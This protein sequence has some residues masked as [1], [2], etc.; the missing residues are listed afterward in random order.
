VSS[1][2][3]RNTLR[4][5]LALWYA[6]AGLA[7]FVAAVMLALIIGV[8]VPPRRIDVVLVLVVGL[9]GA[10]CALA[11]AGYVVAGRALAPLAVMAERARRLSASSLSER[12]PVSDP[13][14]EIGRLAVIFNATLDRLEDSF[15]ELRRFTA[16][17]S[18]ELRTPLTA[19]RTVGEVALRQQ[20]PAKVR[21]SV[22]SMLEE[23]DHMNRLIERL[24]LLA[25]ADQDTI[26]VHLAPTSVRD[27]GLDVADSLGILAAE[28]HQTLDLQGA[29]DV[30]ALADGA[31]LRLALMN[32]LQNAIRY[33]P[34]GKT[35]RLRTLSRGAHAVVEVADEGPGIPL[36]H[37]SRVF[38]RFYRADKSRARADGGAGLGLAIVKWAIAR[39]H[40]TVELESKVGLGSTFRLRLPLASGVESLARAVPPAGQVTER[41]PELFE[42]PE[43]SARA[44]MTEVLARLRTGLQGLTWAEARRRLSHFGLNEV[45]TARTP[46]WPALLW[47]AANNPFNG[48]LVLL[49]A[50]SLLTG[51]PRATAVM[52]VMVILS[53]GL[54][55]WQEWKSRIQAESLRKLVRNKATVQRTDNDAEPERE[56]SSLDPHASEILLERLVPG[57]IVLLSAGDMVPGDLRLLQSRDLF[58]TQSALTGEAMPVEKQAAE[59]WPASTAG[60]TPDRTSPLEQTDLLF[61]G[62]SVISG[63]GKGVVLATGRHTYLGATAGTL[64]GRRAHTAF[65]RGVNEV[66]WL[67]IRFMAVMVPIVFFINGLSK[68]VWMQAFFFAIAVAVGLTPEMLPMIVNANLARG[69]IAMSRRKAIVKR[70]DSIQS[71]GAM[72]ILCTDKTGTLTQDH[73]ALIHHVDLDGRSSQRV[74][75]HAFLNSY[76]QTGLKNLL[77]RAVVERSGDPGLRDLARSVAKVDEIPFDFSRRRMSVALRHTSGALLLICKGAVEETLRICSQVEAAGAVMPLTAERREQIK[78]L[79]DQLNEDGLRVIAVAFK[80][81]PA[82]PNPIGVADES[83]MIFSGFIAFLD[84]PKESAAEA[85][86]LLRDHGVTVKILTGDNATVARRICR[87][88]GLEAEPIATGDEIEHLPEEA[89]A[90]LAERTAVFAK[91][92]PLQKS[93]IVKALKSRSH[94]VGFMGDGINDANALREADVGI[95]VDSGVDIA[96]EAAD[97]ILLEKSLLVLERGVVEGRRT[98]GNVVKYIKMAASSNFGNVLSILIA[99]AALPFLPMLPIQLLV[100]NLL[101][102]V[103]QTAIPWDRMDEEFVRRPRQWEPRTIASFMLC[104]GPV[105]S[106]FDIATFL[107]L[108]F[109]F[110]AT[111]PATQTLF[112]S[113]WFIVGLLTQTLIVHMIRTEKIPFI[114]STATF[115]LAALTLLVAACGLW[116][117]FSPLAASLKLQPLPAAYFPWVAAIVISYCLLTQ[118]IKRI[119]IRRFG[120]WL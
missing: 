110:G 107:I 92:S 47:H 56:A 102:D 93:R 2:S 72:D 26:A 101:Y 84:P 105:S 14:D 108:W 25:Q 27:V 75:E 104:I 109:A 42:D 1:G 76:F 39:M 35:I 53:T 11:A 99:S 46:S 15:A 87:E 34:E 68:G 66:S 78:R 86:R 77:D 23:A 103:S 83:E 19:I 12:L 89:L 38:E 81:I 119:Y 71:L 96:K 116:L 63:T 41:L 80:A 36:E 37:Q 60:G 111:T 61:M 97:I 21:D 30:S 20:D 74:L 115:P 6:G 32:L 64:T 106:L 114:E 65:D 9:P 113:G 85:L 43:Q 73:V 58:V 16:D 10:A 18:H 55:F 50:V 112:Q 22:G 67:L 120:G 5:R 8:W 51:D 62:S 100:Q 118:F 45:E 79:R 88:V 57:D 4:V 17:A 3:R 70:L 31:L 49:G 98:F 94:T 24:L 40:G 52:T 44:S 48:V 82:S 13:H 117:P 54:R 29:Q 95:S 28:K 7:V 91:V 33:S 69:A 59:Q 90:D